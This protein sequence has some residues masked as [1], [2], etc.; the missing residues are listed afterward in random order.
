VELSV[1]LTGALLPLLGPDE[2]DA[3]YAVPLDPQ[4][5]WVKVRA[6]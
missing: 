1:G 6:R 4:R 5:N 2:L 3:R